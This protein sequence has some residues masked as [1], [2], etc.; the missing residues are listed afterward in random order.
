MESATRTIYKMDKFKQGT[1]MRNGVEK[2]MTLQKHLDAFE[3][4]SDN[5]IFLF[6]LLIKMK[7][8]LWLK[9]IKVII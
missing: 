9:S 5:L 4:W 1:Y 2:V 3:E 6:A 7:E 8:S